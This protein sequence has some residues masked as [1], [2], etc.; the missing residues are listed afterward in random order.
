MDLIKWRQ[1]LEID[2]EEL[3]EILKSA[4]KITPERD[5]KLQILQKRIAG[6]IQNQQGR[7]FLFGRLS[8]SATVAATV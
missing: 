4:K 1:D 7:S 2:L 5:N 6:K 3:K 8:V